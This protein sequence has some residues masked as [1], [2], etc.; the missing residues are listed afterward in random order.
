MREVVL[1]TCEHGGNRV[2]AEVAD[3]FGSPGAR[4][5]LES[6]RGWDR[7]ALAAARDLADAWSAPLLHADVSRLVVELNRSEHHPRLFSEFTRGLSRDRRRDLVDRHWRPYRTRVE[8]AVRRRIARGARVVHLSVHAFAPVL[9]GV[10]RTA[11]FAL[12]YDPGRA[13]E[14]ALCAAWVERLRGAAP[15]LRVR[16]NY[17]YRGVDDGFT[18]HL[19]RTFPATRYLGI[20]LEF[21]RA[22]LDR[23]S[24]AAA[25]IEV[26]ASTLPVVAQGRPAASQAT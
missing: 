22:L 4:R 8:D 19:R 23:P 18:T 17:P 12:L 3:R 13:G 1:L 5:A 20:E 16:R 7:G 24:R 10:P 26:V 9:R 21:N 15:D 11:D 2:P 25:T 14:C 6:H